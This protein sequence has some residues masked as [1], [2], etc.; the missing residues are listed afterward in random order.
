MERMSGTDRDAYLQKEVSSLVDKTLQA[1]DVTFSR[2][3]SLRMV[4]EVVS[5]IAGYGPITPLLADDEVNEIM[6][7]GFDQVYVERKGKI[8]ITDVAFGDDDHVMHLID[9]IVAPLGKRI[10]ESS[11]MVDGRLPDGS[12]FNATIPPVSLTGPVLTLSLIHI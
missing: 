7:N 12:R 10:D 3:E 6:V 4:R 11:P 5:E 8:E 9:R 2:A 1:M